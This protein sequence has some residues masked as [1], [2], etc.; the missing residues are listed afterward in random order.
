M[1]ASPRTDAQTVPAG[2]QPVPNDALAVARSV[3]LQA[4]EA[5]PTTR[6]GVAAAHDRVAAYYDREG[7]YAGSTF[8]DLPS[9]PRA[10]TVAD[11]HAVTLLGVE[12]DALSTRRL[13]GPGE[14]AKTLNRLLSAIPEDAEL[15]VA[16]SQQL[17]AMGELHE[18][19][20]LTLAPVG[21]EKT[22]QKWVRAAKLCAR[23]RPRL[24]PVRDTVV[25]DLLGL[26]AAGNYE[27]DYQVFRA[28]IQDELVCEA[29]ESVRAA[30]A[31]HRGV[32]VDDPRLRVLD[33]ALWTYGSWQR[34]NLGS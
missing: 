17:A 25:R 21:R 20:R 1:S 4:L 14:H 2:W 34:R 6:N 33:V 10:F 29:I 16:S 27:V 11:L 22:S 13:L 32:Q 18:E 7:N 23:K 8:L 30:T 3:A 9:N 24:F 26:T 19:V 12:L 15:A 5:A 28:L 31:E